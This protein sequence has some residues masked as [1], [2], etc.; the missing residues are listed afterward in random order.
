MQYSYCYHPKAFL[1]HT[2]PQVVQLD[3]VSQ[4]EWNG[5]LQDGRNFN[6]LLNKGKLQIAIE[7][8]N[9]CNLRI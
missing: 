2:I 3:H 7:N 9:F 5:H 6:I 4:E 1:A 8:E